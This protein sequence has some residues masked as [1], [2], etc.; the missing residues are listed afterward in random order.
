METLKKMGIDP[1]KFMQSMEKIKAAEATGK[2]PKISKANMTPEQLELEEKIAE[3]SKIKNE[4]ERLQAMNVIFVD[5]F[6]H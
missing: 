5:F 6:L 1:R 2:L 3:I 4:R